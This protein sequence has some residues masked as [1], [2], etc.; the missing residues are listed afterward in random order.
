MMISFWKDFHNLP[1][2]LIFS[3]MHFQFCDSKHS[4]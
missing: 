4:I 2:I 1:F 3:E